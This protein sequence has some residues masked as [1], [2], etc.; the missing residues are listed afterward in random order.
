[1]KTNNEERTNNELSKEYK[2]K[3]M[4]T[5]AFYT[6]GCKVNQYETEAMMQDFMKKGYKV[7]DFEEFADIY[8][9]NTCTVTNIADKKSRQIISRAKKR[10]AKSVI[11]AVGCYV[12]VSYEEIEEKK[13]ADVLIGNTHK[14]EIVNIIEEYKEKRENKENEIE[15]QHIFIDNVHEKGIAYEELELSEHISKTR[16]AIKIEDGCD[17]YCSF[18]I[19]PITRGRVR[20]RKPEE[21]EKEI[22]RLVRAGYQEFVLTGIHLGAYG[23]DFKEEKY[24]F[25]DII[26]TIAAIDG[27]KRLRLGSLEPYLITEDFVERIKVLP[28]I[29]PH[30]HLSM[31]SGSD[32]VLERMNRRYTSTDY[33][34]SVDMLR[35]AFVEPAFT[36]DVIVG[37]PKETAEE[38]EETYEFVKNIGFQSIHVF[39]YSIREGTKAA[40]MKP[41]VD[42]NI[43]NER[44]AKLIALG[45]TMG[46]EFVG[47]VA[48]NIETIDVVFEEIVKKDGKQ[49]M[50]GHSSR[51]IKIYKEQKNN[52]EVKLDEI[53]KVNIGSF[54]MFE[55]GIKV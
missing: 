51:Y 14:N 21:I 31:Q 17:R 29:C 33:K 16:A 27:V 43:K 10:N 15:E 2:E 25:I 53:T 48:E 13:I 23:K 54:T 3:D 19:I 28:N 26:E 55:D 41:Q 30:F 47:K 4:K 11:A 46:S 5:V 44:S 9:I 35:K 45:N 18:C 39:K 6:L 42:G 49:Y 37:F 34:K 32:T 38:F 24:T 50:V 12:Q 7:V 22:K 52:T 20:S 40:K 8:V 36:T 1:M